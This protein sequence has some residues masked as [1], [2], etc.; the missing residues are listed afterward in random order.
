MRAPKTLVL[1]LFQIYLELHLSPQ[2][3]N[4]LSL[5]SRCSQLD[6]L[7]NFCDNILGTKTMDRNLPR[8]GREGTPRRHKP[9]A[10]P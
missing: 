6:F 1:L 5:R 8:L 4:P 10:G 7:Q 9:L 2:A 3:I